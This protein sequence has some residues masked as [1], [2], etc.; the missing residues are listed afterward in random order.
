MNNDFQDHFVADLEI[1][2]SEGSQR[3]HARFLSRGHALRPRHGRQR[4][5]DSLALPPR[6]FAQYHIPNFRL[7]ALQWVTQARARAHEA[8]TRNGVRATPARCPEPGA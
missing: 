6:I 5:V 4:K 1:F 3:T 7:L 2:L 8:Y